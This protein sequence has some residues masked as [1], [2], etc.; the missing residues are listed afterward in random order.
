MKS[1]YKYSYLIYDLRIKHHRLVCLSAI[2]RKFM[3]NCSSI[4]CSDNKILVLFNHEL[5]INP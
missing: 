4:T 2:D 5:A 1:C 3:P